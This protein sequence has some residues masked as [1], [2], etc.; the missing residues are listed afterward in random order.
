MKWTGGPTW[1]FG[2]PWVPSGLPLTDN[3]WSPDSILTLS[4]QERKWAGN[5]NLRIMKVEDVFKAMRT[6]DQQGNSEAEQN[7]NH[8]CGGGLGNM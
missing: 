8:S 4:F 1:Y 7:Q 6:Y 5:T 2:V 3:E